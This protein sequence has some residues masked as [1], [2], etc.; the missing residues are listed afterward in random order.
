[1]LG[2]YLIRIR[3]DSQLA[4]AVKDLVAIAP[5]EALS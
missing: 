3:L 1:V 2:V 5:I 4:H